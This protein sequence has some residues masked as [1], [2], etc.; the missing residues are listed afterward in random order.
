M[1]LGTPLFNNNNITRI[2]IKL[3]LSLESYRRNIPAED[4]PLCVMFQLTFLVVDGRGRPLLFK[5]GGRGPVYT[6]F[7]NVKPL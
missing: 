6:L 3:S 7:F 1:G 5:K 2:I 4:T